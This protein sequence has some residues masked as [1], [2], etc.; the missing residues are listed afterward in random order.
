MNTISSSDT[1]WAA[2]IAASTA[3]IVAFLNSIVAEVYRRH[4][5]KVALAAGISGELSSYEPFFPILKKLLQTAIAS[6]DSGNREKVF[7]RPIEKPRDFIFEK[8]VEKLGLLGPA[9]V[10]DTV[11]VYVYGNLNGFRTSLGVISTHFRE[12]SDDELKTR[13]VACLGALERAAEKAVPL[14]KALNLL[15]KV[16]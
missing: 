10:R 4:R 9:L 8:A 2:I 7:F 1:F 5:D 16:E 3:L 14:V 6:V 13:C 12:M 11:Y 15:A